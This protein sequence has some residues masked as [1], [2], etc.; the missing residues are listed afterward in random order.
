MV[1][2]V[3]EEGHP[4]PGS[5]RHVRLSLYLPPWWLGYPAVTTSNCAKE[6]ADSL[7]TAFDVVLTGLAIGQASLPGR[8]HHGHACVSEDIFHVIQGK[9][10]SPL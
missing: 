2:V 6:Y 1:D 8:S 9:P 4:V 5:C 10:G 7:L 3:V